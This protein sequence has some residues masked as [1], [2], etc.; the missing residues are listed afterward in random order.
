MSAFRA[1]RRLVGNSRSNNAGQEKENPS[2]KKPKQ[3]G[4]TAADWEQLRNSLRSMK[5]AID[6]GTGISPE[7]IS[8]QVGNLLTQMER[9]QVSLVS[10]TTILSSP[11]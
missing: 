8:N 6:A 7:D 9:P 1:V 4:P 10:G 5:N 11:D 3:S 2:P